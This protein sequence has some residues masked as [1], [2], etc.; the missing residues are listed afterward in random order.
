LSRCLIPYP[1]EYPSTLTVRDGRG[2]EVSTSLGLRGLVN[3]VTVSM[4]LYPPKV[5]GNPLEIYGYGHDGSRSLCHDIVARYAVTGE[6]RGG[7]T[8]DLCL[9]G[10]FDM[11]IH[12]S[13]RPG[14]CVVSVTVA[15][16]VGVEGTGS[17]SFD[18]LA[19]RP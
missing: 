7:V 9:N 16:E 14:T 1:G 19:T 8:M 15:N 5:A 17:I 10:G 6:C 2:G 12:P 18:P 4:D 3:G 11:L 13:G